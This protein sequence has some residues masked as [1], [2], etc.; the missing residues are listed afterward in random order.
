EDAA[1]RSRVECPGVE[2]ERSFHELSEG[3]RRPEDP[4]AI[5][6]RQTIIAGDPQIS[7]RSWTRGNRLILFAEVTAGE[8]RYEAVGRFLRPMERPAWAGSGSFSW[9]ARMAPGGLRSEEHTSELQS[10]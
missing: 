8:P 4:D 2:R 1:E 6:D 10:R 5:C 3:R 9:D 7:H